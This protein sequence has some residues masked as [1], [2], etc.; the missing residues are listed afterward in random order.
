[1]LR[2][3]GDPFGKFSLVPVRNIFAVQQ[4]RTAGQL[5]LTRH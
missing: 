3:I 1:M 2:Q 4:N 5:G